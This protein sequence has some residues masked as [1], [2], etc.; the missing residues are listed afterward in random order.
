MKTLLALATAGTVV[1][2]ALG[3]D[4]PGPWPQFRGPGGSGLAEGQKPPVEFG[5]AK[6]VRWKVAVPGG[7]S[8]PIIAGENLV[9]TAFENGKLYTIAYH[10][11]DGGEAWRREAPAKEI[12]RYHKSEGSPASSTP[13]TDG[14]R[15]VVYFGSCGLLCYD[16]TGKEQWKVELPPALIPGNFGSGTSPVIADGLVVLVR[17]EMTDPRILA[18]HPSFRYIHSDITHPL[19]RRGRKGGRFM[20]R[21]RRGFTLIELLVVIA[22]IAVLIGLLV[23]AVQKVRE[24]ANRLSCMNNLHQI[25]LACHMYHDTLG[26]LPRYRLCPAPWMGGN[27]LYCDKLTSPTHFTGPDEVW[28]APYDNRV[29]PTSTP[30]PDYDPT[31]ALLWPYVE[32]NKK[33]FKCPD[34]L[35]ITVGSPT[36]GQFY[37]CS[38]G[39]NYVTNGPSGRKLLD[40]INGNGSS[41]IMLVWDHAKTPGCANSNG[42]NRAEL[43]RELVPPPQ[44]IGSVR[45][46]AWLPAVPVLTRLTGRMSNR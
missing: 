5:P 16:L 30:L 9:F 29:G 11:A 45:S 46:T 44:A 13:A 32:G 39:M 12:E 27:D 22:I 10:R 1:A 7:L 20:D 34:G 8:S 2:A 21:R 15:I 18:R 19:L 40:L 17:D 28:W 25:G 4:Q 35:D 31:R 33:I 36:Q 42:T 43:V 24:T 37:Q 26:E 23:P 3:A 41:N 38:Y 14:D 6:N